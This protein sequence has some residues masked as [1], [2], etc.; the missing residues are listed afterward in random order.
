MN[1]LVTN[2][3]YSHSGQHVLIPAGARVLGE[4]KPVQALRRDRL[5]VAF[6]RLVMPDGRTY[7]LDQ[8]IGLNQIGDAGLTDRVNHHYWS[9][10]GAAAAVGLISGLAQFIGSAGLGAATADR[11]VI[12]AGSVGDATAQATLQVMNRFLNRL[13][14]S[15]SRRAP[16]EGVPHERSRTAGVRAAGAVVLNDRRTTCSVEL[17]VGTGSG[18]WRW[19]RLRARSSS[20][21]TRRTSYQTVLIAERDLAALRGTAAPVPNHPADGAGLGQHGGLSHPDRSR[22]TRTMPA[23][24][25]TAG[26]GL[27]GLN[28]GDAT[29][30]A[31]LA[32]ALPLLAADDDAGAADRRR[33]PHARTPIRHHRDHRLGRDDGRAIRSALVARL[34]R[35][36]P[37]GRA[38]LEG[39]VLNGCCATTR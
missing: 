36:A 20:S 19:P 7:R 16:R 28:S 10:F 14:T 32:T 12:I 37:A 13:P 2:P 11:T 24:G 23:A 4:T 15:R 30:A 17:C 33:A 22:I 8:F 25:S 31:Y 34:P 3:V 21:S 9:T 27:Q 6:H 35:P 18:R 29:G 1:C 38:G 39:D 5:A 26:R